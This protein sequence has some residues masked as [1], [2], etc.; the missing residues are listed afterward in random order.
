MNRIVKYILSLALLL[1]L[2]LPLPAQPAASKEELMQVAQQK[3]Q[4]VGQ[5]WLQRDFREAVAILEEL[6]AQPDLSELE[7]ARQG[8][9]YNLACGYSLLGER[10]KALES[11]AASVSA[12][13]NDYDHLS[14]DSDLDNIRIEP[15]YAEIVA[16]LRAASMLWSDDAWNVLYQENLTPDMKA[17]GLAKLWAET[18]YG[19]A[20]FDRA[21]ANSWD[22]LFIAYLPRVR[23][24]VSTREY[25]RVLQQFAAALRDGHTGVDVP[26]ELFSD[27]YSRPSFDTRL[28]EGK[29][30]ITKVFDTA[31]EKRGL[32]PGVEVTQVDGV[33]VREYADSIVAPFH[34]FS[35]QQ[36]RD[37]NTFG[38]YLL[39]GA[40]DE[41][42][43]LDLRDAK[44]R[45][46]SA[47]LERNRRQI[48]SYQ[49]PVEFK[50]L[51][52]NV[53]YVALN[54]FGS[55]AI[56]AAFDSL[57]PVFQQSSALVLDL[58]QNTGGNSSV[59][60]RILGCLTDKPFGYFR[61]AARKYVAVN[62][63]FGRS[64]PSHEEPLGES[65]ANGKRLYTNPVA[66]L[67]SSQTGSAAEDFCVAFDIMKRG[68]IVGE[69]T[70]GST[71]QPLSFGL[72]GGGRG[73]VCAV[74]CTYPDGTEFVGVGVAPDLEI[75]PTIKDIRAGRD[76]V[77][78][79]ALKELRQQPP[80]NQN[81]SDH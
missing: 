77:L 73:R 60:F 45:A 65:P 17:A 57:F 20:F 59:G 9:L 13:F 5:L 37:L 24:T 10:D 39:C 18:K 80:A 72:P 2:Y 42:V 34:S 76:P 63:A 15:R 64:Q 53:A 81:A 71:G 51:S 40:S 23:A 14:H 69:P 66:V 55:D 41:P 33:P 75:S 47:T 12:G 48:L 1:F 8:V 79:A 30:V 4:E 16:P 70:N 19:F 61:S 7:N 3:L 22:S 78:T 28:I 27:L 58:R 44:G 68:I 31:L 35:T 32:R 54:T 67:T 6:R 11:L 52:N 26:N 43:T 29:V 25:Y 49:Q 62:R 56:S 50:M 21:P 74:R 38:L 36:G 46:F